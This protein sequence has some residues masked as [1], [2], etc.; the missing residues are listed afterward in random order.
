MTGAL[1]AADLARFSRDGIVAMSSDQALELMD[2]ALIIDE[3]YMSPAPYRLGGVAGQ[4][5]DVHVAAD[6][7]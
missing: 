7:R 6:V 4:V 5:R 1:G 2:T 3:P